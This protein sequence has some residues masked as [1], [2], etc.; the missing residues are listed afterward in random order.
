[1]SFLN[2]YN[3]VLC[4]FNPLKPVLSVP[5]F[6]FSIGG[7]RIIV[8]NHM[9]SI[10]L[11]MVLLLALFLLS[12]R[13]KTGL[14]PKGFQNL[15]ELIC[16][17]LRDQMARPIL[18]ENTDKFIGFI[19]TLFFF[20]LSLNL[21]GMIPTEMIIHLTTGKEN[22]FGGP[23]TANIWITGSLAMISFFVIHAAGIKQQGLRHYIVNFAPKVPLLMI[24]PIYALEII[25]AFVRPVA[26][27][28]RLFAN[29]FAGHA[30]IATLLGLIIIFKN[31]G[32]AAASITVIVLMSFLEIFVAF[33]QA[34][35]FAFLTT[36]FVSFSVSPE[37]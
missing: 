15:I 37:H 11:A 13:R 14:I 28:I 3:S 17:Y 32:V 35:I 12:A 25:S 10:T 20:I 24:L 1:M 26:L 27:A 6:E 36:L 23:A 8:S 16:V 2:S 34:Y 19:W 4:E 9:F 29:I 18:G 21:L 5:L 22:H 31:Y 7:H 33:L 30:L